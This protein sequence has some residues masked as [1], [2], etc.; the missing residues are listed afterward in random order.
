MESGQRLYE[1]DGEWVAP[2]LWK[3]RFWSTAWKY[4]EKDLLSIDEISPILKKATELVSDVTTIDLIKKL[5]VSRERNLSVYDASF[6]ALGSEL[7]TRLYTWD[8]NI[9]KNCPD[10]E[11]YPDD[12]T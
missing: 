4:L 12:L 8:K 11:K 2:I 9:L 5:T 3:Y 1:V 7:D 6:V 10:I